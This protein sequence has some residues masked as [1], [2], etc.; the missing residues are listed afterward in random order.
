MHHDLNTVF[1]LLARS[2]GLVAWW[3]A[4]LS[5]L[6]GLTMTGR[7]A[8]GRVTAAWLLDLHRQLS[9]TAVVFVALHVTALALDYTKP[10]I[11]LTAALIPMRAPWRPGPITV[12]VVALYLL[13]A[14]ELTSLV[15]D[16]L[17][18]RVWHGIHLTSLAVFV[19]A[20]LHVLTTGTDRTNLAIQWSVLVQAAAFVFLAVYRLIDVV[21]GITRPRRVPVRVPQ[22]TPAAHD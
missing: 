20:T 8:R 5:V 15:R 2:T 4:A 19:L 18:R 16:R 14:V 1:W 12:G 3:L 13:L 9:G 6:W 22:R 10:H 21:V 7:A 11:P 17:P